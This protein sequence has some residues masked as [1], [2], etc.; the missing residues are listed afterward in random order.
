[1]AQ[2]PPLATVWNLNIQNS[3]L[4]L[5]ADAFTN[6][7]NLKTNTLTT[8]TFAIDPNYRIGYV[9]Q[10]NLSVQQNLPYSFQVVAGYQGSKGTRLD[11]QFQPWVTPPNAPKAAYPT[12]YVYETFGGNSIY[13]AGS[14]QLIRRFRGGLSASGGYV[15]SKSI[16]DGGAAE[17]ARCRTG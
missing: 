13:H 11:R 8:N 10:W 7:A 4:L 15:F 2:Q 17:A 12:G 1:M 9:Q 6:P 5:I 3:P 14:V 16:D